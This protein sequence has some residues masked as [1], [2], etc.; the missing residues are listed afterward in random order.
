MKIHFHYNFI[1][2]F[3][4]RYHRLMAIAVSLWYLVLFIVIN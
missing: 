3:V 4:S 2:T 1:H